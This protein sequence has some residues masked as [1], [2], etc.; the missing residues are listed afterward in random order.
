VFHI[1]GW[2]VAGLVVGML[3][4]L[5]VPGKHQLG[6]LGTTALGVV[7]ALAGGAAARAI[8]GR[9]T[10]EEFST[11]AWPGYLTAVLGAAILLWL[12][13]KIAKRE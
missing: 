4:R 3:A 2:I 13:G 11:G 12:V 1:L 9:G 8:W 5:L 6:C 10:M 7:G